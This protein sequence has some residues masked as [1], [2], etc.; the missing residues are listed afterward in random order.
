MDVE[1]SV[2]EGIE[3][4][5]PIKVDDSPLVDDAQVDVEGHDEGEDSL[6]AAPAPVLLREHITP[7]SE[8]DTDDTNEAEEDYGDDEEE[9]MELEDL[10][11]EFDN[12][13]DVERPLIGS[14]AEKSLGLLT[15]RFLRLLQ[16]ARGG[17]VDLNTAADNLNVKQ[18]RR[19]YDITNVMEG[20]GLIEKKSKN[21]IQWK[22]GEF[23]KPGS[24]DLK[25]EE[26][27]IVNKLKRELS[28]LDKEET[29][30]DQQIKWMK[31]SL[32]N[33][34]E[35]S[36]NQE[37]AYTTKSDLLSVFPNH[38]IF[39]VQAPPGTSVDLMQP[40]KTRELETRHPLR[41]KSPCGPAHVV[42]VTKEERRPT[43][44]HRYQP[45]RTS[46]YSVGDDPGQ[47]LD[48]DI[49]EDLMPRKRPE[50][51]AS[52]ASQD[53]TMI[54]LSPPPSER[55]YLFNTLGSDNLADMYRDEL[56]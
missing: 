55:D 12:E 6:E 46:A 45:Y 49:D 48:E 38:M 15:Q 5:A 31:Q 32:R 56:Y 23:R 25:P 43:H 47:F 26:E 52:T 13:E 18:K 29:K 54:R 1:K 51:V 20:I 34:C 39:A 28:D 19:I 50:D 41:I 27:S 21:V 40:T 53:E 17:L 11:N 42:M 33:V 7:H 44:A 8:I 36:K 9:G 2:P 22:G 10:D 3:R 37:V 4:E 16:M 24:R 35:Y 30:L 14:R